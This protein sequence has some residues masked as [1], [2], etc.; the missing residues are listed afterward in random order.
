MHPYIHISRPLFQRYTDFRSNNLLR[1]SAV[2]FSAVL[3]ICDF[4][5]VQFF[6]ARTRVPRE[7]TVFSESDLRR[8]AKAHC[9]S[10]TLTAPHCDNLQRTATYQNTLDGA[11][12]I[13]WINAWISRAVSLVFRMTFFVDPEPLDN[14]TTFTSLPFDFFT[15]HTV[16]LG[17]GDFPTVLFY[18]FTWRALLLDYCTWPAS[19]IGANLPPPS[20]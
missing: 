17:C 11:H 3:F 16:Q 15:S 20:G 19:S 5:G 7:G 10:M 18:Y 9:R 1:D 14:V 13:F 12:M 2:L 8:W 6:P 4:F